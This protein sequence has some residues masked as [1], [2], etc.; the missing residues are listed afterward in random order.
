[1]NKKPLKLRELINEEQAQREYENKNI[2]LLLFGIIDY[3]KIGFVEKRVN[4][5]RKLKAFKFAPKIK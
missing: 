4:G 3:L 2:Y 1:M 5:V